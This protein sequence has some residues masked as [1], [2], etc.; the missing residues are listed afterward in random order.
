MQDREYPNPSLITPHIGP[1]D[2]FDPN[3][4]GLPKR[5]QRGGSFMCSPDYCLGYRCATRMK[6]EPTSGTFHCG[7]R[8][9]LSPAD[10]ESFIKKTEQ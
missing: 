7:F 9:V 4:P 6:G 5:V 2:S 1:E 10:Y 8:C 3:E